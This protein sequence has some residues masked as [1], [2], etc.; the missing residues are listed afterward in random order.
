MDQI[1]SGLPIPGLAQALQASGL[2]LD[3]IA[4]TRTNARG[5]QEVVDSVRKLL[6]ILDSSIKELVPQLEDM[7]EMERE[8]AKKQ[9]LDSSALQTRIQGLVSALQEILNAVECVS[10]KHWYSRLWYAYQDAEALQGIRERINVATE[11][12]QIQDR[13]SVQ[14]L[15]GNIKNHARDTVAVLRNIEREQ[16]AFRKHL[17]REDQKYWERTE[18]RRTRN[19]ESIRERKPRQH[20]DVGQEQQEREN[21][22][23]LEELRPVDASYRSYLNDEKARLQKGTREQVLQDL[24]KWIKDPVQAR[25]VHILH[26]PAGMGKSAILH[27]IA[28]QLDKDC[29]GASFF[30]NRGDKELGNANRVFTTLVY[31]LAHLKQE[32]RTL[33]VDATTTYLPLG[34]SQ[35]INYQAQR[36][37]I[38]PLRRLREPPLLLLA[39]IDGVDECADTPEGVVAA[40]LQLLCEAAHEIPF[41]RI[42][43]ATRPETY[44]MDALRC[45]QHSESIVFRDLLRDDA[46]QD[47]SLFIRMEFNKCAS[48]SSPFPLIQ[49]RPDAAEQLAR[50]SDGL[51]I[52]ASTVVRY[53]VRNK[54]YAVDIYD[55]LLQ[56]QGS[57]KG[58][59]KIHDRLDVLY[60]TILRRA[61]SDDVEDSHR[62]VHIHQVLTW[63]A[64]SRTHITVRDLEHVGIP[65]SAALHVIDRLRSV[66]I[67]EDPIG[68]DT[69]IQPCHASF[70][71][72]LLDSIRCTEVAFRVSSS[73]GHNYIA[74]SLLELLTRD[75]G[76]DE[77]EVSEDAK[78]MESYALANWKTHLFAAGDSNHSQLPELDSVHERILVSLQDLLSQDHVHRDELEHAEGTP[79]A[80]TQYIDM[81]YRTTLRVAFAKHYTDSPQTI[82]HIR[83]VLT[84]IALAP[85]KFTAGDLRAVD[86]PLATSVIILS[87][88]SL[89][90]ILGPDQRLAADTVICP[91]HSS[92][93]TFLID[94][95][96]C[97]DPAFHISSSDGR[98]Q[99]AE[100]II[101]ILT[102]SYG[103]IH[104]RMD[105]KSSPQLRRYSRESWTTHLTH[106]QNSAYLLP[107]V[108]NL[109][110]TAL[111]SAFYGHHDDS[112]KMTDHMH[113]FL[114]WI[115]LG[116]RSFSMADL[117]ITGIPPEA[118]DVLIRR[119][120]FVFVFGVG[121]SRMKREVYPRHNSFQQYLVDG[122]RC[123]DPALLMSRPHG[124]GKIV[125]G[126]L[127][128]LKKL[129]GGDIADYAE[130][131]WISHLS[132]AHPTDEICSSL[133][134]CLE[135]EIVRRSI[136]ARA[137]RPGLLKVK[138]WCMQD[139]VPDDLS[140]IVDSA[141]K[142][143]ARDIGKDKR[144][145]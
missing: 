121:G 120:D 133:R 61:F 53:L 107:K 145:S 81:L 135:D 71:Q 30:F 2:L 93:S 144:A 111:A 73:A 5:K 6:K 66:L 141:M 19:Q 130:Q 57:M 60:I 76:G 58:S 122:T 49:Q 20:A 56:S 84:W 124:H 38:E 77:S 91:R 74:A 10:H 94:A 92:F 123:T 21:R 63:I 101:L 86:I 115:A 62:M 40:M 26:G 88:L 129:S 42:L 125:C 95:T 37:F 15:L 33:I 117:E 78:A 90:L 103:R 67:V 69:A 105:F 65:F 23:I 138:E 28:R 43:V 13:I 109:Y 55:V 119:L 108:D 72:F 99:I 45:C 8:E 32:L 142:E 51:F 83:T 12:F 35:A 50:I 44:I 11:H 4:K 113:Q 7:D 54:Y 110:R 47:I 1:L 41:L 24:F 27:A 75:H 29:L 25:R 31:Q 128:C 87:R 139:G 59:V 14:A 114:T 70:P 131:K 36:L 3:R 140:K 143:V 134:S 89:T 100:A 126:L 79:S 98:G 104:G 127:T 118:C 34:H 132:L 64:L 39:V 48:G 17:E 102:Q 46:R 22:E 18:R 96:R 16:I 82:A 52:Y 9:L 68:I 136:V 80:V 137:G 112:D 116:E 106:F 85:G 97:M